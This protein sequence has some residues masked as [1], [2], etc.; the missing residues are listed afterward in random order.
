MTRRTPLYG[1]LTAEALSLTGTRV[2]MV[3]LPWFVLTT[4]GSATQTGLV[5]L[6]E[7]LPLVVLKVLG[8][9][10]IDRVGARR[11]S[12]A[13]DLGSVGVVGAIPLLHMAGLL[14]LP[15]FLVLVAGAGAL[16]GPGDAAKAAMLPALVAHAGVPMERAT[17]L[18]STVERGAGMLGFA[19]AGGLVAVVGPTNALVVDAL[20]FLVS[21]AVLA[22]TTRKLASPPP[23]V[24]DAEPPS[25]LLQLRQ[26]WEFLRRDPVLVGLTAMIAVTNLLDL[27]WASGIVPVWARESGGGAALVGLSFAVFSGASMLG[28]LVAA[29]WGERIPRFRTYLVAFLVTGLPRFVV[30]A[31]GAPLW[32]VFTVF[33]VGGFAS[34]FLNPILGAVFFERIPAHLVGRVSSLSTGVCFALMPLGGLLGG[35]LITGIGLSP[36]LLVIGA[37]YFVATMSPAVLPAFRGMDRRPAPEPAPVG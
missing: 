27:A 7:M 36:A 23:A 1:W 26:G 18:H 3:A 10:I 9:P 13:C 34:G 19:F 15:L 6:A 14:S 5:A 28:A 2:S 37:A 35:L 20:S 22:T 17:G 31:V 21:A 30:M 24:E 16:R 11:V 29:G 4:T 25:Y 32:V 33:V 8:G 12:I